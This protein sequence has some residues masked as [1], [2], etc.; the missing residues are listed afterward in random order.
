M[1]LDELLSKVFE[2]AV[3][4]DAISKLE[5]WSQLSLDDIVIIAPRRIRRNDAVMFA[6]EQRERI[7]ARR[8]VL[9]DHDR[10]FRIGP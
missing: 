5:I 9:A 10:G 3:P 6:L 7:I 1:T 2:N 8:I 4:H